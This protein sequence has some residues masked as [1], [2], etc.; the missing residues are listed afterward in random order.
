[1]RLQDSTPTPRT[2]GGRTRPH[3][4][5]LLA[6][7]GLLLL[8][9]SVSRADE[10]PVPTGSTWDWRLSLE[11]GRVLASVLHDAD[12]NGSALLVLEPSTRAARFW[13][14]LPRAPV[15]AR[16]PAIAFTFEGSERV[17]GPFWKR[18]ALASALA[19]S[20]QP[21]S[22]HLPDALDTLERA[23]AWAKEYLPRPRALLYVSTRGSAGP[24]DRLEPFLAKCR[25]AD[26]RVYAVAPEAAFSDNA[27]AVLHGLEPVGEAPI[28]EVP[29]DWDFNLPGLWLARIGFGPTSAHAI[30][31]DVKFDPWL[32]DKWV[33]MRGYG[34]VPAG[35][36]DYA[37]SRLARETGGRHYLHA[38]SPRAK[39]R[40]SITMDPARFRALEPSLLSSRDYGSWRR[41][42][43]N[44][45][46]YDRALAIL[47]RPPGLLARVVEGRARAKPPPGFEP[48]PAR[49]TSK[50]QV[51][52]AIR[53]ARRKDDLA[54]RAIEMLRPV[55]AP[56]RAS[57][58]SE[59]FRAHAML[60]TVWLWRTR[61][62]L[63][64]YVESAN[65]IQ[66]QGRL[67]SG[68]SVTLYPEVI[69][70]FCFGT[71][72]ALQRDLGYAGGEE[73]RRLVE[74]VVDATRRLRR[75]HRDTP[76]EV[77]SKLG[78]LVRYKLR[79]GDERVRGPMPSTGTGSDGESTPRPKERPPTTPPPRP[80]V[81][82]AGTGGPVTGR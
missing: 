35:F 72:G 51:A 13:Q 64:Q 14:R 79:W 74:S 41:A 65:G 69:W 22:S 9:P 12:Q 27:Q 10:K 81:G 21:P 34:L 26:C 47:R 78:F 7:V 1:M 3:R 46:R 67:K 43:A 23:L 11:P 82:G 75:A 37:L 70:H 68:V 45:V 39:A 30:P 28:E 29:F 16:T 61:F 2:A 73:A 4:A 48:L 19:T 53:R 50:S 56:Y 18:D 6:L 62:H 80:S 33:R 36:G 55:V 66:V 8:G 77:A 54:R 42:D 59:R 57:E 15:P 32:F 71:S 5:F 25:A 31:D 40:C 52:D 63:R 38:F 76:W 20:R 58:A 60:L 44:A 49:L 17:T 24:R